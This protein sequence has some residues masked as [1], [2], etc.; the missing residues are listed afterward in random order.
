MVELISIMS[1]SILS[2]DSKF[3]FDFLFKYFNTMHFRLQFRFIAFLKSF[4]RQ[5]FALF[6]SYYNILGIRIVLKGKIGKTGSVR[7]KKI[8]LSFGKYGYSNLHLCMDE[9][10]GPMF[11]PTGVIG[12]RVII[13]Y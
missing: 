9:Y 1:M 13:A 11:T 4:L 6:V 10:S 12:A 3:I 8:I 7:K 2:R 5:N